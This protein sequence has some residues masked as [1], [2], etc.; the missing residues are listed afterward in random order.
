MA[1]AIPLVALVRRLFG[2][3]ASRAALL[4]LGA[5]LLLAVWVVNTMANEDVSFEELGGDQ[6]FMFFQLVPQKVEGNHYVT[7]PLQLVI[8]NDEEYRKLFDPKL[9]LSNCSQ[10]SPSTLIPKVDFAKQTVL[11]LWTSGVCFNTGFKRKVSRDDIKKQITYTVTVLGSPHSCRGQGPQSLN[12]IA[13]P[14]IPAGYQVIF[15]S[16]HEWS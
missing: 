14:K 4:L 10:A 15:E 16:A 11:A 5:C 2:G 13:V 1:S 12:L 8:N 3:Y 9:L 7:L 6:C